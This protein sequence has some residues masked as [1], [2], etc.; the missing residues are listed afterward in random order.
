MKTSAE[1][2]RAYRE[3]V[4]GLGAS[5]VTVELPPEATRKLAECR[6]SGWATA[7]AVA[8]LLTNCKLPRKP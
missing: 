6:R 2:Q 3:R 8:W 7:E 5:I 4:R 1:R